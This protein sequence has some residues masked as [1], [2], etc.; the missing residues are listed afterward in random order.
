[1]A[2]EVV[3]NDDQARAEAEID[4]ANQKGNKHLLDGA[5]G[6]GKTTVVVK[7]VK[8]AVERKQ[9]VAV[10]APTHKAL[11]VLREKLRAAGMREGIDVNLCTTQSLLS[12]KPDNDADLLVFK[13][14]KYA[15]PVLE[16]VVVVDETSMVDSD[17]Y[18]HMERHL[19]RAFVLLVGDIAQIPPVGE[20]VS[21][22]F[23]TRSRSRLTKIMRQGEGNPL[24]EAAHYIRE[25]QGTDDYDGE[26][27]AFQQINSQ[28]QGIYVPDHSKIP[29]WVAKAFSRDVFD[30]DHNSTRYLAWTN[31]AV[32]EANAFIRDVRYG[33]DLLPQPF[34]PGERILFRQPLIIDQEPI[35]DNSEEATCVW[36]GPGTFY[37]NVKGGKHLD[38]Y[39]LKIPTWRINAMRDDGVEVEIHMCSDHD[40]KRKATERLA[41]EA[42]AAQRDGHD[43]A[44]SARWKQF[45]ALKGALADIG[46]VYGL[47]VH[48]SQGS[49]ITAPFVDH[50]NIERCASKNP[51]EMQ[52][53]MYTA[54]TRASR[55]AILRKRG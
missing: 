20:R 49:T 40:A 51:L 7:V 30:R 28:R 23:R 46:P 18:G 38:A 3:L 47:T 2:D 17:L 4:L 48:K 41:N 13:R 54:L 31:W 12:L 36:M 24:L 35:F 8:K 37:F 50:D 34:M 21:P 19:S 52:Q 44:K 25:R 9:S 16:E 11:G 6:T 33:S 5:A 1:M 26:Q 22:T 27:W 10:T 43:K 29:S 42:I 39:T 55:C 45:H 53:L 14:D 15:Q 32:D